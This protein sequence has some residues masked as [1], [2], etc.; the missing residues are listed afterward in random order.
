MSHWKYVFSLFV[1]LTAALPVQADEVQEQIFMDNLKRAEAGDANSQFIVGHR[2]EIGVG[3]EK[4]MAKAF[5]WY[6]KAA[7]KGHPLA[8]LKTEARNEDADK[9]SRA[10]QESEAARRAEQSRAEAEAR[11]KAQQAQQAQQ[12][13]E[14]RNKAQQAQ[15]QAEAA[16]KRKAAETTKLAMVEAKPVAVSSGK[17]EIAAKPAE[18]ASENPVNA[19]DV[20][21]SNLWQANKTSAEILP[22]PNTSCLRTATAEVTCF[23]GESQQTVGTNKL[24]YTVKSVMNRFAK[25]G[26][27][28]VHY[29]YNVTDVDK[30]GDNAAAA[31]RSLSE[32]K[33]NL[34]WQEPGYTANCRA[35]SDRSI[36]CVTDRKAVVQFVKM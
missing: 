3:T 29:V 36:Q 15:Q 33:P 2:Y 9:E 28:L 8:L 11:N 10:R 27:F 22:S 23:T 4:N 30:A 18:T 13:A 6:G 7:Q 20:V 26:S 21:L 25:D 5:E 24:S 17:P 34:G 19:I 31:S 12:Q 14:A 35:G 16:R 1:V 32:I